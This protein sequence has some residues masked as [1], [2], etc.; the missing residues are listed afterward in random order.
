MV[1]QNKLTHPSWNCTAPV[2]PW[3]WTQTHL[4]AVPQASLALLCSFSMFSCVLTPLFTPC[5]ASVFLPGLV[6]ILSTQASDPSPLSVQLSLSHFSR[7]YVPAWVSHDYIAE[8][9]SAT[10]P[11]TIYI[12]FFFP[13]LICLHRPQM[14]LIYRPLGS[15]L[16]LAPPLATLQRSYQQRVFLYPKYHWGKTPQENAALSA[17]GLTFGFSFSPSLCFLVEVTTGRASTKRFG[18]SKDRLVF[19]G[20]DL[21]TQ[22]ALRMVL[23]TFTCKAQKYLLGIWNH[24]FFSKLHAGQILTDFHVKAMHKCL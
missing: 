22:K 2:G 19:L 7:C 13:I 15:S 24:D 12:D 11:I 20:G 14:S 4:L 18:T 16:A 5:P 9:V 1:S 17:E 3:I 10:F 6:P 8:R 21:V 23:Y